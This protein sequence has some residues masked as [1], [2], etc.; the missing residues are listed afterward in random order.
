MSKSGSQASIAITFAVSGI[1]PH[2]TV[3]SFGR[4]DNTGNKSSVI[5]IIWVTVDSLSHSS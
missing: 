3:K 1:E 2:S 5:V 4:F